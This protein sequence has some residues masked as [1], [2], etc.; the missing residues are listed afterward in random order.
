MPASIAR[1]TQS[2]VPRL[3]VSRRAERSKVYGIEVPELVNGDFLNEHP[4]PEAD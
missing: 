4:P 3:P 2:L 1:R